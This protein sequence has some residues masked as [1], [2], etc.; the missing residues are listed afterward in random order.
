MVLV[1]LL[2]LVEA[3]GKYW[4]LVISQSPYLGWTTLV[5]T[6]P[7][8]FYIGALF[9]RQPYV[10]E[11]AFLAFVGVRV[12]GLLYLYPATGLLTEVC[13][14]HRL[15]REEIYVSYR[16]NTIHQPLI[17][18]NCALVLVFVP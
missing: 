11:E 4:G 18:C 13:T 8:S 16:R 14:W 2:N 3:R 6:P 1:K 7:Q 5:A 10:A 17:W 12:R 15:S 9:G